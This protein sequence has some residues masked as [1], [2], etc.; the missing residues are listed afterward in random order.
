T[1]EEVRASSWSLVILVI[2]W[3]LGLE[4]W[5]FHTTHSTASP[6]ST[7]LPVRL[8]SLAASRSAIVGSTLST[9]T[10][11]SPRPWTASANRFQICDSLSP[12]SAMGNVRDDSPC[13]AGVNRRLAQTLVSN[14]GE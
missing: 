12:G 7:A 6:T 9:F 1:H 2:D 11:G 10:A 14:S 5:S 4:H 13:F 8:L 3:S